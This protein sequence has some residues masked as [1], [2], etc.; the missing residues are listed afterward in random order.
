MGKGRGSADAPAVLPYGEV[1]APHPMYRTDHDPLAQLR[2]PGD[3]PFD[4][5]LSGTVFLDIVFTGLDAPPVLG[6]EVWTRGM[7]SCP[8]GVANLAIA[9][10]R[11]GLRTAL[12]AAFGEDTYGDFSWQILER[13]E[14]VDLSESRRFSGWHSPVTV[15]LAYDRDRSMITHGHHAP[16]TADE[17]IGMPPRSRACFVYPGL[18]PE[19]WTARAREQG[20]ALFADVGWDP[21]E[22]W[23]PETLALLPT[24][25]A[26]LPNAVEAMRYTRTDTPQRALAQLSELVPVVVVTCGP[27]GA[28]GVDGSTGESAAVGGLPVEALDPTGAGDV[29]GAGFITGTLAGW[30]LV[31]RLRFANL[32]AALSVQHFGGSLSAPGWADLAAWWRT[33]RQFSSCRELVADY[34]FLD[35][36]LPATEVS[37]VHRAAATVDFRTMR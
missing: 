4:V 11:L 27:D 6:T 10:R 25:D 9:L 7:G 34:G 18:E 36:V 2:R 15:S 12:A 24:F 32:C 20:A 26:F 30:P 37:G 3:P 29:F 35:R 1:G 22:T 31:E 8:G 17:M 28:M 21:T 33:V 5:F 23:S 13:Q 19:S 14:G 16:L